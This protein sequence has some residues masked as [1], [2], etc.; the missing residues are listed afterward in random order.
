[1]LVRV[2]EIT[3]A[4]VWSRGEMY[5]SVA[6]SVLFYG[7]KIWV[8]TGEILKVLEGF[9]HQAALRITGVTVKRGLGGE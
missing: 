2:L 5:K 1:M 8:V 3:G 9:H 7:S 6:Q 4:A